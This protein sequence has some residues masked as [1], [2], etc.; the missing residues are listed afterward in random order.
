MLPDPAVVFG[1]LSMLCKKEKQECFPVGC[2][3]PLPVPFCEG[4]MS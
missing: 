3:P 2:V 1:P 4:G